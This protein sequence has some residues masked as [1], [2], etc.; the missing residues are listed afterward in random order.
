MSRLV[1]SMGERAQAE[2][3]EIDDLFRGCVAQVVE[4]GS[5]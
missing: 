5:G 1:V 4:L 2:A 3:Q